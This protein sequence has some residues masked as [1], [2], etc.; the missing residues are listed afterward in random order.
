MRCGLIGLACLCAVAASR[1]DAAEVEVSA[2][3]PR[4]VVRVVG[5]ISAGD[6][7]SL[8]TAIGSVGRAGVT[9]VLDS[10]GGDAAESV[11]MARQVRALGADTAVADGSRCASACFLVFAAGARRILGRGSS[12]AV[13][14]ASEAD[15]SITPRILYLDEAMRRASEA[16]GVPPSVTRRMSVAYGRELHVL[17]GDD[18]RA[19]RVE[20][21]RPTNARAMGQGDLRSVLGPTLR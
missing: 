4:P 3:G 6:A 17:D 16:Y 21:A 11:R 1:S 20:T 18:L 9:V 5:I 19:M 12:V 14:G 7:R 8:A 15:G 10:P 13:H 2:D